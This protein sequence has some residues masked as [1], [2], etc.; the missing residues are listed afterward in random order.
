MSEVLYQPSISLKR[1]AD[2]TLVAH[3]QVQAPNGCYY[4]GP[5][6]VET[7]AD[8]YMPPGAP[9]DQ[10]GI[11]PPPELISEPLVRCVL[12]HNGSKLCPQYLKTVRWRADVEP[13]SKADE[14]HAVVVHEGNEYA[15]VSA[16][17]PDALDRL[18]EEPEPVEVKSFTAWIDDQPPNPPEPKII[19]RGT[20]VMPSPGYEVD[21]VKA[22]SKA[23]SH[24]ESAV[25]AR[26]DVDFGSVLALD[27]QTKELDGAFPS[28]LTD[29]TPTYSESQPG[30]PPSYDVVAILTPNGEVLTVDVERVV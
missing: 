20:V 23:R 15:R 13:S 9:D 5:A 26:R 3:V 25:S 4:A 29:F 19:V 24:I 6:T 17:I 18:E 21:L 28:V 11:H 8:F 12:K 1:K 7:V 22:E 30:V 27:L 2:G 10:I 16:P 14:V